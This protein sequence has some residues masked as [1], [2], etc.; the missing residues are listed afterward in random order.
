M[1]NHAGFIA[2]RDNGHTTA[3]GHSH[4]THISCREH[5]ASGKA[6]RYNEDLLS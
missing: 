5:I 4:R 3:R 6:M 1:A 2:E